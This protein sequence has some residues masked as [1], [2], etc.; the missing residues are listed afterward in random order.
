LEATS[1]PNHGDPFDFKEQ[2]RHDSLD[3][4][5]GFADEKA[6]TRAYTKVRG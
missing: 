5:A 3:R 1:T 6:A 2:V 4:F